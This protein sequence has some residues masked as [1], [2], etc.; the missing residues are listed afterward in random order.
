M[1]LAV[2]TNILTP[3]RLPLFE[4]FG[5]STRDCTVLL[6]AE[7]EANRHWHLPPATFTIDVLPGIHFRP[8][9]A[10]VPIHLNYGILRRLRRLQPDIVLSGGFAAANLMAYVYCKLFGK[11][12]V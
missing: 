7:H 4:Y 11:R 10:E 3:Y 1:K 12:Y 8:T 2:V 9:G 6:Q 5:E